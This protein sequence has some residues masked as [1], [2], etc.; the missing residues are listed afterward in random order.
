MNKIK[1][2]KNNI[3]WNFKDVF[4]IFLIY[5]L[6]LIF[7]LSILS[8]LLKIGIPE[9]FLG[10]VLRI[11]GVLGL[12]II[13]IVW[14]KRVKK[15]NFSFIGIIQCKFIYYFYAVVFGVGI[16]FLSKVVFKFH[17]VNFIFKGSDDIIW[18]FI[19]IVI[20]T[21]IT[22]ELYARGVLFS[23]CRGKF[24]LTRGLILSALIFGLAHFNYKDMSG[25]HITMIY[26]FINGIVFALLY[27]YSKSIFP[28]ILSHS[29][30]NLLG[31]LRYVV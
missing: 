13:S 14:L 2:S 11:Y 4:I 28:S 29:I 1:D 24:G 12:G 16:F 3:I 23:A 7:L 10:G 26:N 27:Y 15:Q 17:P 25:F 21:P 19:S 8:P 6:S 18:L 22:E 5:F 30:V 20:F 31:Y 9:V